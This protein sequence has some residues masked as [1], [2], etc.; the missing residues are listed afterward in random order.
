MR[1][2]AV[3]SGGLGSV[4][5][6]NALAR[7]TDHLHLVSFDYGQK[8]RKKLDYAQQAAARLGAEW[9]LIDLAAAGLIKLLSGSALTDD[10]VAVPNGHY[11]EETMKVTIVPNRNAIMLAIA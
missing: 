3:V 5:L 9:T 4:T 8:H 6:A 10:S 7:K 11:A 1:A 2:L